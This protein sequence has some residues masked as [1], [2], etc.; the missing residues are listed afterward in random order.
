[1]HATTTGLPISALLNPEPP[2]TVSVRAAA[3]TR[4]ASA[5]STNASTPSAPSRAPK[6]RRVEKGTQTVKRARDLYRSVECALRCGKR[7]GRASDMRRHVNTQ[8]TLPR[9]VARVARQRRAGTTTPRAAPV[10]ARVRAPRGV[11]AAANVERRCAQPLGAQ[12]TTRAQI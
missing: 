10:A 11:C 1:M 3:R 5:L 12:L 6:R 7:F 8:H 4:S 2:N 9:L